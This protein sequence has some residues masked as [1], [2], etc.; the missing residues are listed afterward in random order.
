MSKT[1]LSKF[2]IRIGCAMLIFAPVLIGLPSIVKTRASGA[3]PVS[4]PGARLRSNSALPTGHQARQIGEVP[5]LAGTS[6]Y[7]APKPLTDVITM[8]VSFEPADASAIGQAVSDLYDPASPNFHH[9]LSPQEFGERFGRSQS[10]IDQAAGWLKSQGLQ[11]SQTWPSNLSITFRGTVDAVQRAFGVTISQY[12]D[13]ASGRMFYTN[14]QAPALPSDLK[15]ITND[16]RGLNNAYVHSH[17]K[18]K[19]YGAASP[20]V[21]KAKTGNRGRMNGTPLA[22]DSR[23]DFFMAPSDFQLAYDI[24][25]AAAAGMRGQ[26][27]RAGIVIDSG[28]LPSD[29]AM[30]RKQ[31]G[32]PPANVKNIVVPDI[33]GTANG[34]EDLETSLDYSMI[35]AMAPDAEIDVVI[36]P[37]LTDT[38][39]TIAEQYIVNTLMIPVVNESFGGCEDVFFSPAEQIVFQQAA[40]EGIAFFASSGDNAAECP[41]NILEPKV[42]CPACYDAVTSVG[43]TSYNGFTTDDKGGLIAIQDEVV[44]NDTPGAEENCLFNF[45]GGSGGGG[46][47]STLVAMPDYQL[48][49][50]GFPGGVP[51]LTGFQGRIVPDVSMLSFDPATLVFQDGNSVLVG[52]TSMSSPLWVG[53]MTLINQIKGSVQGSPNAELYRLGA[54]QVRNNGPLVFT[55]ITE[56]NNSIAPMLPC[57]PNGVTG[58][59]AAVGYDPASGWGPPDFSVLGKSY[60]VADLMTAQPGPPSI[61][62]I[63]A[64]LDGD[65]VTLQVQATDPAETITQ[66]QSNLLD[67]NQAVVSQQAPSPI[68]IRHSIS[69]AFAVTVA[70]LAG[71]PSAQNISLI[72]TDR[73]GQQSAPMSASFSGADPGGPTLTTATL[74]ANKL[75]ISGKGLG[76]KLM[77]EI[78]GVIVGTQGGSSGA[79]KSF[80]GSQTALNLHSG[81]N[82]I[83]VERGLLFSNIFLLQI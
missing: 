77:L 29:A 64:R 7:L 44:W 8:I 49:A 26:G 12:S 27:Q 9:W 79:T 18:I 72:L 48:G 75:V 3:R 5:A 30:Y 65:T 78:N 32:L 28:V 53:M 23:K 24:A 35:S 16:L 73:F 14:D 2:I 71:I 55:D 45:S 63:T 51:N 80:S 37:E 62:E 68:A 20:A 41:G 47:I 58:Y 21:I 11:I 76:G 50:A 34:S 52:G 40:A 10:E 6:T 74:G 61:D 56:G 17:G 36:V 33:G 4:L 82:R 43:G 69:V 54:L 83:R 70:G 39:T 22:E 38:N 19:N 31:F 42:S 60:G 1:L 46:G 81:V 67:A 57:L 25:P 13:P 15:A 66:T 59:S